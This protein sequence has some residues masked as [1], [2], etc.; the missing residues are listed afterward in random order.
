M[1]DQNMWLKVL[2][3]P[4]DNFYQEC[5]LPKRNTVKWKLHQPSIGYIWFRYTAWLTAVVTT[6]CG[7]D[8]VAIIL[9]Q[10]WILVSTELKWNLKQIQSSLFKKIRL[11]CRL[12][13]KGHLVRLHCVKAVV[14]SMHILRN[15]L[16]KISQVYNGKRSPGDNYVHN[17]W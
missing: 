13:N 14:C 6:Y 10:W 15:L 8:A 4:V 16:P 3:G 2:A 11:K 9:N 12:Q 1:R 17:L 5:I 7:R